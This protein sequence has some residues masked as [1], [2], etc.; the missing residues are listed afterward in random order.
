MRYHYTYRITNK[1]LNKHYYGTRTSKIEPKLDLGIKYFSSSSDKNFIQ[2]QKDNPSNYKYKVIKTF[3]SR[4]EA[5]ELEIK[6]HSR[7]NVGTNENFYNRAKQ[8][9]T[10]F[11]ITGLFIKRTEE[12]QRKLN[13]SYKG[14][15]PWNKGKTLNYDVWNKGKRGI[16]SEETLDKMKN[17]KPTDETKKKMSENHADVS[18]K[19]NP[20][21][22]CILILD[23]D[24][25]LKYECLGNFKKVCKDNKLPYAMFLKCLC[26]G[27]IAYETKQAQTRAKKNGNEEYIGW[28]IVYK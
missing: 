25:N 15:I 26:E 1:I 28:S 24:N 7:F 3:N 27:K 16:F 19:N 17:W 6:L 13:E 12:H 14:K 8:T 23:K 21:A 22:K 20:A 2:D 4:E 9:S 18:G 5:L 11:D 10:G